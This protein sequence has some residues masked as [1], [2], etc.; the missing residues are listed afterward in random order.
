MSDESKCP[1]PHGKQSA[2]PRGNRDWWPNALDVSVL[3]QHSPQSNPMG[4]TFDYTKEFTTRDGRP[5]R[6][7]DKGEKVVKELF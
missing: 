3:H 2:R 5:I 6:V 1:F 4:A 7:V